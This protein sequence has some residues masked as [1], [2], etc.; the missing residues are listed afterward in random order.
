MKFLSFV[1]SK[2]LFLCISFFMYFVVLLLLFAFK[3][4]ISLI[5]AFTV[6]FISVNII[7]LLIEYFSKRK[8]YNQLINNVDKL[9]KSYLVLET[10]KE[11]NFYEGKLLYNSLY[12]INKSMNENVMEFSRQVSD[13]KN[14]IEMWIHE[15]K[16]PL[17]SCMLK[18]HNNRDKLNENMMLQLNRIDDY[19]EQ[20]LY[21][22]RSE[23]AS[24]DY[25]ISKVNLE[26]C[27]N[28]VLVKNK[29]YLLDMDISLDVRN[30]DFE[31]YTD[32]KWF[33][34]I[35]NQILNNSIKYKGKNSI[36]KI[37]GIRN[38]SNVV[39]VIEDNGKGISSADL[40]RVFEKS[41]TG[42]NGRDNVKSTGMGLFIVKNLCDKLGH[43]IEIKSVQGEYTRVEISLSDNNFYDEV[44]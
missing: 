36:I 7:N 38:P 6:L 14:Y 30:V 33:M 4:D 9:D 31:V 32:A 42:S 21:Y 44:R 24:K 41:F 10:L 27:V 18:L 12:E 26:K 3:V 17:A 20:V 40:P 11:P 2:C 5:I 1:K 13:F 22:V 43:N 23:N 39:L 19:L 28:S 8:F 37:Y 29:D 34:F 35:I 25:F 16:I 15:V